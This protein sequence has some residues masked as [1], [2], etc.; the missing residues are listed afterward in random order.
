MRARVTPRSPRLASASPAARKGRGQAE[1]KN[2]IVGIDP[3][4]TSPT[5]VVAAVMANMYDVGTKA[6]QPDSTEGWVASEVTKK[7]VN[8]DKVKLVFTWGNGEVR[9]LLPRALMCRC[10]C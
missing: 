9:L 7:Q 10:V 6:W 4:T 2:I 1:E 8:G 5:A 3:R